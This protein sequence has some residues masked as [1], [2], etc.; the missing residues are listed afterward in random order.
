MASGKEVLAAIQAKQATYDS[1]INTRGNA[2]QAKRQQAADLRQA[3]RILIERIAQQRLIAFADAEPL[4]ALGETDRDVARLVAERAHEQAALRRQLQQAEAL[5]QQ[6]SVEHDEA[7]QTHEQAVAA[8]GESVE[9]VLM[10]VRATTAQQA[11]LHAE[12]H[13][14]AQRQ[15]AQQELQSCADLLQASNV[16]LQSDPL[17]AYLM[18]CGYGSEAYAA[19]G[20]VAMLDRWVAGVCDFG[21]ARL[22]QA[23]A[24]AQ[25][26]RAQQAAEIAEIEIDAAV[27]AREAP[28]IAAVHS[29]PARALLE[30]EAEASQS[31][32]NRLAALRSAETQVAAIE[33][34]LDGIERNADR[35]SLQA[36]EALVA[37]LHGSDDASLHRAVADTRSTDDD[38]L[39][40]ELS[41][42]RRE[43]EILAAEADTL[44]GEIEQLRSELVTVKNVAREFPARGLNDAYS[45]F[46]STT[47]VLEL[48][49]KLQRGTLGTERFWEHLKTLHRIQRPVPSSSSSGWQSSGSRSSS[50]GGTSFR[51]GSGF[52]GGGFRSGKGF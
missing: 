36:L 34:A 10:A 33:S 3:E 20:P 40:I 41:Q 25:H 1:A 19:R 16:Q 21:S 42:R 52:K 18:Q 14:E 15:A 35:R 29:S 12:E 4:Q 47:D 9:S 6:R 22:R 50:F 48:L 30:A 13:A 39:A 11:L 7:A 31:R 5:Q 44:G 28:E 8:A 32:A 2:L 49:V 23:L 24:Q 51:S 27:A 17:T 26:A 38:Q 37:R 45:M 43:L 46:G